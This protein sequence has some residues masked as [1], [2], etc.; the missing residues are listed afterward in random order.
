MRSGAETARSQMGAKM[1]RAWMAQVVAAALVACGGGAGGPLFEG[2][3]M[4]TD[5]G[6]DALSVE[7]SDLGAE[8][9][10]DPGPDEGASD[11]LPDGGGPDMPDQGALPCVTPAQGR[12][13]PPVPNPTKFALAVFHFNIQYVA[14]GLKGLV[15]PEMDPEGMF[16]F[17]NDAL[18]DRIVTESFEP[19]LD[20]LLEHPTFAADI[21]MQG[22]MLDVLMDRHPGVVEK[23]RTLVERGQIEVQSFHYADQLFVAHSRFTMEHSVALNRRAF[24]RACLPMAPVVFAQEGQF[25]EGMLEVMKGAG[26]TIALMKGGPFDYQYKS[27][28]HRLLYTL[29]G[30]DVVTTRGASE[31]PF[32]VTW[33]FVDDGELALTGDMNPYMGSAFRY[34]EASAKRL[35]Q[36]LEALQA[37]G[38]FLTTVAD[39]VRYLKEAGVQAEPLPYSL[40]TQ[41]RPDDGD[42]LFAWMGRAGLWGEDEADNEVLSALE[43]SRIALQAAEATLQWALGQGFMLPG[44]WE[45]WDKAM[46]LQVLGEVSDSTGWNPWAGEVR[47]SLEHSAA[48]LETAHEILDAVRTAS[49]KPCLIVHTD[50]GEVEAVEEAPPGPVLEPA[51]PPFDVEVTAPGFDASVRW[52]EVGSPPPAGPHTLE[53]T[54]TLTRQE[55]TA[56]RA[57]ISFPRSGDRLIY[58]PAMLDEVTDLPLDDLPG[59]KGRVNVP[60]ANGLVGLGD[61]V[62]LIK[63]LRSF[64]LSAFFPKDEPRVSFRDETLNG[65]GPYVWRFLVLMGAT[66]AEALDA[67][68]DLNVT[69][70]VVVF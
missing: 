41:W 67:A 60:A 52:Q 45:A 19:L 7:P 17:D 10:P 5:A 56:S 20:L 34:D 8:V 68:R 66:K 23:M 30:Q 47:Y 46:R 54:V 51:E 31:G 61:G 4:K 48:A 37:D 2:D 55:A 18:E 57:T 64:H 16:D 42:N 59:S 43:R 69:P 49:G 27:V 9:P 38:W 58:S 1:E 40:D 15:P 3:A 22:Y 35:V 62:F 14:G 25:S 12:L 32:S 63:D 11:A 29:R 50:T 53:L 44:F 28:P 6:G 65:P 70:T 24:E 26:Q 13:A 33:W 21:E 36:K 39:Y